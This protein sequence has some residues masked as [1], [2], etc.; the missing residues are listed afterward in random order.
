MI[1][2]HNNIDFKQ[3]NKNLK[4][5]LSKM[6]FEISNSASL[7]LLSR[8]M[9]F[10]NYNTYKG[11]VEQKEEQTISIEELKKMTKPQIQ[12]FIRN[13]LT[14]NG[15]RKRFEMSGYEENTGDC[16]SHNLD[17]LNKFADLGIYDYT[18]YLFLDFYKG[19]G[20]LY[21]RYWNEYNNDI[22][23]DTYGGMTTSEIIYDVFTR[24]IFSD[25]PKRR[26]G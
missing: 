24:T 5:E 4:T 11:I 19:C 9:G 21:M 20:Y 22:E 16:T 10:E 3:V 17:I 14:I 13:R 6:N 26:R 15:E 18:A 12:D 8:A 23:I 1:T 2:T 7:N 25:K